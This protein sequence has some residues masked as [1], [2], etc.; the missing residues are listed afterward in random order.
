MITLA[1]FDFLVLGL[2]HAPLEVVRKAV[3]DVLEEYFVPGRFATCQAPLDISTVYEREPPPGGSHGKRAVFFEPM[4]APGTTAFMPNYQDGWLTMCN[5]LA[6]LMPGEHMKIRACVTGDYPLADFE[7]WSAGDS[8]RYVRAMREDPS[9]EFFARGEPQA[10]EDLSNYRK[11]RIADRLDRRI[12]VEYLTK[13]GWDISQPEFWKAY[14]GGNA[15]YLREDPSR[16]GA[17]RKTNS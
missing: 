1:D 12:L 15:F 10:F 2:F 5:A 4:T 17:G 16:R 8:V 14:S 11:K 9:W 3:G 7:M 13:L 6:G